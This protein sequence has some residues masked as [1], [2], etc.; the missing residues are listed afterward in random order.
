VAVGGSLSDEMAQQSEPLWSSLKNHPFLQ[1]IAEATLPINSFRFYL[2]QDIQYLTEFA[3]CVALATAK[4]ND[5][6]QIR[7]FAEHLRHLVEDELPKNEELLGRAIDLGAEDRGGGT[8]MAPAC[9]A[10]TAFME[11][12]AYRG[13]PL[14][15]HVALLPCVWSYYEIARALWDQ[16]VYHP[17]YSEWLGF[18][19]NADYAAQ[20][21]SMNAEV[22]DWGTEL[23]ISG[24]SKLCDIFRTS[25]RFEERFWSMAYGCETWSGYVPRDMHRP[26]PS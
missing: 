15:V 26:D 22:D 14:E 4:A 20:V 3:R 9:V 12:T 6:H 18:F 24:R 25:L 10:Y 7:A 11:A 5:R 17:V 2:E 19:A 1:E 8:E 16:V 23:N 21:R 13:G